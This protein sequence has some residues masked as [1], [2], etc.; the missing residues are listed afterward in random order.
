MNEDF[1]LFSRPT[2]T[3]CTMRQ[4]S[5]RLRPIRTRTRPLRCCPLSPLPL[6]IRSPPS[7]TPILSS[8]LPRRSTSCSQLTEE[9]QASSIS[10]PPFQQYLFNN[11]HCIWIFWYCHSTNFDFLIEAFH[12]WIMIE[13]IRFRVSFWEFYW[14][15]VHFTFSALALWIR[16][17]RLTF[18][19]Y[20]F[21][22]FD[23]KCCF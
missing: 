21:I 7:P 13:L 20:T 23:L 10:I 4:W 9:T 15:F 19:D 2:A 8:T 1:F 5:I 14:F 17:S 16:W 12:F 11:P 18:T 22:F 6:Q 3:P